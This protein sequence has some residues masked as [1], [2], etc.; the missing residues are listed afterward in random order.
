MSVGIHVAF[1]GTII[2]LPILSTFY[3]SLNSFIQKVG[4]PW[5]G[6]GNFPA[7]ETI[8]ATALDLLQYYKCYTIMHQVMICY[9]HLS[10]CIPFINYL[11]VMDYNNFMSLN[12]LS[13]FSENF[14]SLFAKLR[15]QWAIKY[16]AIYRAIFGSNQY[17]NWFLAMSYVVSFQS[18]R[19]LFQLW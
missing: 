15:Y 10:I 5:T 17:N 1:I 12:L 18:I 9:F 3:D 8:G 7:P 6:I 4:D 2:I 16:R 11:C 14:I 19:W 13:N